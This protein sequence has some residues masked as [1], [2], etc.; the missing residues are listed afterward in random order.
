MSEDW[1][2]KKPKPIN[3]N[4][5]KVSCDGDSTHPKVYYSLRIGETV[6]CGYCGISWTRVKDFN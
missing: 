2:F 3:I 1:V 4:W 5:D 6:E